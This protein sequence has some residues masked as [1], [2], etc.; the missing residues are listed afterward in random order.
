MWLCDSKCKAW[1]ILLLPYRILCTHLKKSGAYYTLNV[2]LNGQ[3]TCWWNVV[4]FLGESL[5]LSLIEL[6]KETTSSHWEK[7]NSDSTESLKKW[8]L[9]LMFLLVPVCFFSICLL[10]T[11]MHA[12]C[13]L[14][15]LILSMDLKAFQCISKYLWIKTQLF[16]F[17]NWVPAVNVAE[18]NL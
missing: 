6:G 5:L 11:H 18:T 7:C 4:Q 13:L 10:T 12:P 16:C 2:Q 8:S 1:R 15:L 9:F 17:S 3:D 14:H